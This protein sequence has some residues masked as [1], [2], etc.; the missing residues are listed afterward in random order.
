VTSLEAP[1]RLPGRIV[2]YDGTCGFCDA[3]VRFL[4]DHDR[5]GRLHYAPL[6][7]PT[8]AGV[9]GRHPSMPPHLDSL[10]LVEVDDH[11]R[12]R[13]EW[14]SGAVVGICRHLPWPWRLGWLLW[15]VPRP[16][17][18]LGYRAFA[19]IRYR[20]FGRLDTCRVPSPQ[21]RGR[22]LP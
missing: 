19:R 15:W 6:D 5:D 3:S 16:L 13:V 1:T 22:F 2:L 7:G 8:A 11:G 17:R 18:D 14:Y 4:L 9:R 20:I 12:E 21:E 10:V